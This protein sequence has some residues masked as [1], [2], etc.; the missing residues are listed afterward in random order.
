[1][2]KVEMSF[3]SEFM[4]D[5]M[6]RVKFILLLT[7]VLLLLCGSCFAGNNKTYRKTPKHQVELYVTSWC[8]YCKK[9]EAYLDQQGVEYRK[10]DIEKDA[11]AAKR[12]SQLDA[13]KGV[14]FAMI[15]G[16]AVHGWSEALYAKALRNR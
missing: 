12:K 6:H 3:L 5:E 11:E 13:R 2:W 15:N 4:E 1:M 14:P 16:V 9:A 10:Y 8:P 7:L